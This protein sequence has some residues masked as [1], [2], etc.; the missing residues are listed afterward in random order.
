MIKKELGE[1]ENK[2][3]GIIDSL[4]TQGKTVSLDSIF[5]KLENEPES[6]KSEHEKM[7][8]Y[9]FDK[10][11]SNLPID[12]AYRLIKEFDPDEQ[13][14]WNENPGCFERHLQRREGNLLFPAHRRIVTKKEIEEAKE[15]DKKEQQ[16]FIEKVMAFSSITSE[17]AK[18]NS[19]LDEAHSLLKEVQSLLQEAAAIG[20]DIGPAQ[21]V[22]EDCEEATINL[23]SEAAPNTSDLF[24]K[25]QSLCI[26][27]R[28]RYMAQRFRNDSPILNGEEIPTLLSEDLHTIALGGYISRSCDPDFR[29]NENDI[30]THLEKALSMGFSK[31]RADQILTAWN[32]IK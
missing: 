1:I 10:Y 5:S 30:K 28:S 25:Q 15:L 11:G 3:Q 8:K 29:P 16:D 26:L 2:R 6:L 20:G 22:L 19:S 4:A 18:S 21:K 13:S 31:D 7:K 27:Q 32:E 24:K 14:P 9:L 17:K 12:V 23:I